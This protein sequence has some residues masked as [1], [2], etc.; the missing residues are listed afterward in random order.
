MVLAALVLLCASGAPAAGPGAEETQPPP[1]PRNEGEE[2]SG[3]EGTITV[4]WALAEDSA[5]PSTQ[6]LRV[7][8]GFLGAPADDYPWGEYWVAFRQDDEHDITAAGLS[9]VP[10]ARIRDRFAVG[11][12]VDLGVSRRRVGS[13]T[14][15]AGMIGAGAEAMVRVSSRWDL[16]T[17]VEAAYR[18]TSDLEFQARFGLRFHHEKI[19]PIRRGP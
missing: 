5:G 17:T 3:L 14:L 6:G 11:P 2:G 10:V 15:F 8:Y 1:N 7:G 13:R 18:T 4:T 16:V 12:L 9:V 19:P